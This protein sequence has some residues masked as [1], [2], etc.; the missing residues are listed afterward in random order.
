VR[1]K[2][3]VTPAAAWSRISLLKLFLLI[4]SG[5]KRLVEDNQFQAVDDGAGQ[6]T[7]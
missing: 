7:V 6:L 4:A 5:G 3:T 1:E 2:I